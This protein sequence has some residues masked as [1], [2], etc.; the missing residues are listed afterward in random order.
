[1]FYNLGD[2]LGRAFRAQFETSPADNS[3]VDGYQLM[4]GQYQPVGPLR[5][6]WFMGSQTPT[7]LVW[8]GHAFVTLMSPRVV[9]LLHETA[10]TG[11]TS[12]PCTVRNRTGDKW[13]YQALVVTGR[14]GAYDPNRAVSFEEV[15]PGGRYRG[16]KGLYFDLTSWDGSDIFLS[17]RSGFILVTDRVRNSF[18][19]AQVRNVRF[20]KQSELRVSGPTGFSER[21]GDR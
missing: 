10:C 11:W 7:D 17:G 4:S 20:E 15:M 21:I 14:C 9:D 5:A 13:L 12:L 18:L 3:I 19:K 16:W 1:M 2:P 6:K 8:T